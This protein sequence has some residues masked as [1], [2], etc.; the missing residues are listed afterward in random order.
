M[1]VS[2][3]GVTVTPA[4]PQK[5]WLLPVCHIVTSVVRINISIS[6]HKSFPFPWK[7]PQNGVKA[8]EECSHIL[9]Q[10]LQACPSE[11]SRDPPNISG[12]GQRDY[13]TGG[14]TEAQSRGGNGPR[15][16]SRPMTE[17]GP[18]PLVRGDPPK[19]HC[20]KSQMKA[21]SDPAQQDKYVRPSE[22]CWVP[23]P[24]FITD[25][26]RWTMGR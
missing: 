12:G 17:R 16:H 26:R 14:E 18:C 10:P 11:P 22:G 19:T 15:S 6:I 13:G 4:W 5:G 20:L 2:P 21:A 24:L 23:T 8:Q 7:T 3:Q 25:P 9:R 1:L